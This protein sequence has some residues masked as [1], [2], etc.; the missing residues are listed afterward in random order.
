MD[1]RPQHKTG[2]TKPDRRESHEALHSMTQEKT[3]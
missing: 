3:L 1:Q 2:H